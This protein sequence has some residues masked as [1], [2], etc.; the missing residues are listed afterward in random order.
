MTAVDGRR[1]DEL[2]AAAA[3]HPD[4][5][6]GA[7]AEELTGDLVR[8]YG[9]GLAAIAERVGPEHL[10]ELCADPLIE[11]LLL[12]HDLHPLDPAARIR[13][14]LAARREH[15]DVLEVDPAG[16]VRLRLS[17][18]PRCGSAQLG[19]RAEI[20]AAVRDAAPEAS[21]VEIEIAAPP[22]PLLQISS[23]HP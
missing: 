10:A 16:R 5:Q 17:D 9:A 20:E 8:L 13:R 1:V 22:R 21:E 23:R 4:P 7:L 18:P 11:S 6:V 12:V 3:A 19:V 14:A 15:V 2:L